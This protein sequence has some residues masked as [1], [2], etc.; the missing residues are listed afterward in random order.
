M[1]IIIKQVLLVFSFLIP[2]SVLIYFYKLGSLR[3]ITISQFI[4]SFIIGGFGSALLAMKIPDLFIVAGE[5]YNWNCLRVFL[6]IF[7]EVI[8][9]LVTALL[10][11][12]LK[13]KSVLE[14][15]RIGAAVGSG[16]TFIE[17]MVYATKAYSLFR[18]AEVVMDVIIYRNVFSPCNHVVWNAII[19]AAIIL[20]MHYK[21]YGYCCM[22]LLCVLVH[23]M[24]NWYSLTWAHII[25]GLAMWII[26]FSLIE[27]D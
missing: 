6:V 2:I 8:K 9:I 19:G 20:C 15:I 17:T 24:C 16:F 10:I 26:L 13:Q 4:G 25:W 7:E 1:N 14:G 5:S 3:R 27:E 22:F 11:Q 12:Y 23:A 21:K 18:E